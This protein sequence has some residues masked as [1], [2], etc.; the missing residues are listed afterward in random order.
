VTVEHDQ[1]Q[2]AT[3]EDPLAGPVERQPAQPAGPRTTFRRKRDYIAVV[4]I[5]AVL[6]AGTAL[7]WRFSDARATVSRTG[8]STAT[9]PPQP[10][11][12]PATMTELWRADSGATVEPVLVGPTVVTGQG[13]QV[14][15][16]DPVT[17]ALRWSYTRENLDL[18][19]VAAAWGKA[20][21]VYHKTRGCSEVTA[22]DGVTGQ[23][24][25]ARDDDAE[26]GT[27]L[28][29]DGTYV[30]TT[31]RELIDTWRSDLVRT[32]QYGTVVAKV[33]PDK[34]PRT[35]CS[36]SSEAVTAG[37]IGLVE[38]CPGEQFQRLTVLKPGGTDGDSEKPNVS[39]SVQMP[40][41]SGRLVALTDQ[42]EAV[43]T[44][45]PGR[46]TIWNNTGS[47]VGTLPLDVPN[48]DLAGTPASPVPATM[49]AACTQRDDTAEAC[50]PGSWTVTSAGGA[51]VITWFTGSRVVALRG[52]NLTPMWTVDGALGP[53]TVFAD[54]VLVPIAE[55]LAVVDPLTG[56]R[57]ATIPIDRKGYRGTV[58][59]GAI[60]AVLIE[61]RGATVVA[62]R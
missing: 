58:R 6:V 62:L 9:A 41:D 31:G 12:V 60:G 59:L 47:Q 21:A 32:Q 24:G 30:T 7:W 20:L 55:G 42:L 52:A 54:K 33:N 49:A 51:K 48:A 18:C 39:F 5:V 35:G 13:H 28:L 19:T 40:G 56:A 45:N 4:V 43:A 44:Q 37:A 22:L 8:P 57:S 1:R 3:A 15:G 38:R 25:A 53:G 2:H 23:R 14:A 34:Q 26:L 36:Y 17:G 61:Q 16:R 27:Q 10:T 29:Y 11:S 50:E 46:L